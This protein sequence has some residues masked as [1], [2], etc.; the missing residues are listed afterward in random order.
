MFH[1]P[2]QLHMIHITL[3]QQL[4][5][6]LIYNFLI[7]LLHDMSGYTAFARLTSVVDLYYHPSRNDGSKDT[8]NGKI[9]RYH[10]LCQEDAAKQVVWHIRCRECRAKR[11]AL[12]SFPYELMGGQEYCGR[13]SDSE[14]PP[15]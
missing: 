8:S 6:S 11:R 3:V 13:D 5:I 7:L 2:L 14:L 10:R 9:L 15:Q 1:P 12:T 4:Y